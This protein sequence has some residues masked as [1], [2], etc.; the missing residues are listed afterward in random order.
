MKGLLNALNIELNSRLPIKVAIFF[1]GSA[2]GC[3][4]TALF[5]VNAL[6]SDAMNTLFMAI[7]ARLGT[8]TGN[9]YTVFNT[10]MLLIGFLFARRYMGIASFLQI[11][12]Q[13]LFINC[14][15]RLFSQVPWLFEV[16]HWRVAI[17]ACSYLTKVFGGALCTSMCL[18]TAGF[19]A[20]L[21]ALADRIKIE[22]KYLKMTSEV[23]YFV[24]ALFLDGVYGIMTIVEVLFYGHGISFFMI[25]LNRT[26]WNEL[27]I[28]DERNEL[29]RNNRRKAAKHC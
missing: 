19:E 23:I 24:A 1:M 14:W 26:L 28:A 2:I 11:L 3:C 15:L 4:G 6:G 13:G 29:S 9:V 12:V 5:T 8:L 22:Y 27:G 17:A 7:A 20:C 21:F 10:S 25:R 18:G 16:P